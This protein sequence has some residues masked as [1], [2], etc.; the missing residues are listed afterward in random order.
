MLYKKLLKKHLKN[1]IYKERSNNDYYRRNRKICCEGG[2]FN[3][4]CPYRGG[5]SLEFITRDGNVNVVQAGMTKRIS[6]DFN[7]ITVGEL[8]KTIIDEVAAVGNTL[9]TKELV[10]QGWG[11]FLAFLQNIRDDN[12]VIPSGPYY[13]VNVSNI[14]VNGKYAHIEAYSYDYVRYA[15]MIYNGIFSST[16]Y[17]L[18]NLATLN[19][20]ISSLEKRILALESK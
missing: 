5:N 6:L 10:I 15:T 11:N 1:V 20:K 13:T 12:Y 4:K 18:Y 3:N 14:A 17:D 19:D 2:Q 9:N 7:G 8:K 16:F